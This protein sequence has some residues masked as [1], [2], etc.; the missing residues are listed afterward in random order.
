MTQVENFPFDNFRECHFADKSHPVLVDSFAKKVI[1]KELEVEKAINEAVVEDV[2]REIGTPECG[3]KMPDDSVTIADRNS[4]GYTWDGMLP[5]STEK[6]LELFANDHE[7]ID[8]PQE[9]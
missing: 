1:Q 9:P 8:Q 7:R 6:A 2:Q 3:A 4:F 5:L